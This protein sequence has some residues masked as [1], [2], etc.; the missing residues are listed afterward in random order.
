MNLS[1]PDVEGIAF[2]R[3]TFT[4]PASW[5]GKAILLDF[6]GTTYHCQAWVDGRFI[7]SHEGGY[8]PFWFD[9]SGFVQPG[10]ESTLVV[11]VAAL[12]KKRDV[13]GM[14]L[15]QAPLSKHSWYYVYG[16]LWGHVSLV[17]L[18]KLACQTITVDPDLHNERAQVDLCLNNRFDG[19]RQAEVRLRV[20]D[21]RGSVVF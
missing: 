7:G 13:D 2:Y 5:N 17:G 14:N 16:G 11:R 19:P 9:V 3:T 1:Y 15:Y 8:T 6:E 20:T 10:R 21:P 18:P 12:S 4:V